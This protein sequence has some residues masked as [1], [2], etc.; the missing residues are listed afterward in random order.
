MTRPTRVS[1]RS[2]DP[3]NEVVFSKALKGLFSKLS[4]GKVSLGDFFVSLL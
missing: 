4:K 1:P 3:G 2:R